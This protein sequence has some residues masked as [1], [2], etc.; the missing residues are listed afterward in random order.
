VLQETGP[1]ANP[2]LYLKVVDQRPTHPHSGDCTNRII[3]GYT[4]DFLLARAA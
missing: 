3:D 1:G 2:P 4:S